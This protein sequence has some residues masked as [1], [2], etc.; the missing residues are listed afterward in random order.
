[1]IELWGDAG[2]SVSASNNSFY[3]VLRKLSRKVQQG[4][5]GNAS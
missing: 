3:S 2:T 4:G 1:M 5:L